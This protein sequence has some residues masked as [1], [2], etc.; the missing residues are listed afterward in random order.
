MT[1]AVV[2]GN[3][4]IEFFDPDVANWNRWLKR[5]EDA[6]AVFKVADSQRVAYFLHFI[7]PT[8]F[9]L[10]CDKLAPEDP[11][12]QPYKVL[13]EKLAEFY[14]P[15][16]LEI[17]ENFRFHQRKQQEGET[18]EQFVAALQK[19]SIHCNFGAYLTTVLRNHVVFGLRSKRI[20]SRLLEMRDLT[21][22]KAVETAV[23]MELSE[24]DVNQLQ[25]QMQLGLSPV[26]YVN[27]KETSA[28]RK[29]KTGFAKKFRR[30]KTNATANTPNT[31]AKSERNTT[32]RA[33]NLGGNVTCYRCGGKHLA[34]KCTLNK[35]TVCRCCGVKGHLQRVCM[36]RSKATMNSLGEILCIQSE[37][38]EHRGKFFATV[39]VNEIPVHFEIDSG[40]AVTIVSKR[41]VGEHFPDVLLKRSK[42][43]LI[44]FCKTTIPV[45]GYVEVQVAYK[46]Y[47]KI[48][49]MY[50]SD[51]ER[52]PLLGR[53]WIRQLDVQLINT[54]FTLAA[55]TENEL[56]AI[57]QQYTKSLDPVDTS[58]KTIQA[59]FILKEDTRPV[60]LKSRKVPFK[61]MPMVEQEIERL[62][63]EGILE[64]TN[65]STWAMPIVPVL[66]KD[67]TVRLCGD[68]SVTLN[69][70]LIV[71]EHPL[72]T[73]DEL[74]YSLA[75]GEK[76][77]KIDLK[78]AYL[79]MQVHANERELLT[80][81]TH[82]GLYKCSRLMYGVASAPAIWQREIENVLAGIPGVSVFLDD[83]KVTGPNDQVHLERLK[84]VLT[85][86]GNYNIRINVDKS[87][88]LQSSIHYC[89]YYI[90]KT[91]V[92]KEKTKMEAIERMP[93]PTNVSELRAFLGMINYYG[94][95]IRNLRTILTPLH[96]LLQK[97]EGKEVP[98]LWTSACDKAFL[99]AKKAFM[100]NEV[101]AFYNPKLPLIVACDA[102]SYGV[103]AVLSQKQEDGTEYASCNTLRSP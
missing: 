56:N 55:S 2:H 72:P 28:S 53:E 36:R 42:L 5:F 24:K 43:Q 91:G 1:K 21:F 100:S 95:F 3:F 64:K 84:E 51:T 46:N 61:L 39:I 80:L 8:S 89:G 75:G 10:I 44:T 35:E 88:F 38:Q 32:T 70:H 11:Y 79:Q 85:R 19:L 86:L 60:F 13:T 40:A 50:V 37:H 15:A 81:N 12:K 78:Q 6:V 49:H 94:R 31:A 47:K 77:S 103:G 48:L 68:F 102:S 76:F 7:G 54:V 63:A 45:V 74:F 65:T 26:D 66:K 97:N 58:I 87:E 27:Q 69:K 90:D 22:E 101:L 99:I 57:L 71:D 34:S 25:S 82:K 67:N 9:D 29:N 98:F 59:R 62:V 23:S 17:A 16:P 92:H 30:E 93:R 33:G 96:T 18:V 4:A 52:D 20:Q 73:I 83:I 41:F 14:S